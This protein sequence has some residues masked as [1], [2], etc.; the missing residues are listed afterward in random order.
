[1]API[2]I[3]IFFFIFYTSLYF[4]VEAPPTF[5]NDSRAM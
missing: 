3:E 2:K 5:P 1:M 4:L